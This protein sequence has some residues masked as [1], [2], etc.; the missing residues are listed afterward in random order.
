MQEREE[1]EVL[2]VLCGGCKVG[3]MGATPQDEAVGVSKG[4]IRK[5][6]VQQVKEC[7]ESSKQTLADVIKIKTTW[8]MFP[9]QLSFLSEGTWKVDWRRQEM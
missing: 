6:L 2:K 3:E 9:K 1:S 7:P 8:F 5:V 4:H